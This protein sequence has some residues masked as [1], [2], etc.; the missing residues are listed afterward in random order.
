MSVPG[1][2]D[3]DPDTGEPATRPYAKQSL[4][5]FVDYLLALYPL[6]QYNSEQIWCRSYSKHPDVAA[7]LTFLWLGWEHSRL[8]PSQL[9]YW[10][11]DADYHLDRIMA[12]DGPFSGCKKGHHPDRKVAAA[13]HPPHGLFDAPHI[14][15]DL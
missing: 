13:D 4:G 14:L 1:F 11:R 8:T 5:E 2:E 7:R 3:L 9:M 10:M 15:T 6:H 12:A